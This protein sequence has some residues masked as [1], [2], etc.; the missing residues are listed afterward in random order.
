MTIGYKMENQPDK[1]NIEIQRN[2]EFK[3]QWYIEY[4]G[5][6]RPYTDGRLE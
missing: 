2:S 4:E 5:K 1:S 3:P 6:W